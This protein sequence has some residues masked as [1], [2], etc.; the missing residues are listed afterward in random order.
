MT[1]RLRSG[2][3]RLAHANPKL[4]VHLLPLLLKS[5]GEKIIGTQLENEISGIIS[6]MYDDDEDIVVKATDVL[7]TLAD[8]ARKHRQ[9]YDEAEAKRLIA[10]ALKS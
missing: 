5:A 1:S 2:L 7:D 4:R 6:D 8:D 10:K 9:T 3:I